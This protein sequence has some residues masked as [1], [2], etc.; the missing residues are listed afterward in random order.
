MISNGISPTTKE[1]AL[2]AAEE[3]TK[4]ELMATHCNF[5]LKILEV[6]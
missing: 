5:S 4:G 2:K 3:L 6:H 1:G